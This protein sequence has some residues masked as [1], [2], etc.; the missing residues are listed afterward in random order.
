MII[1]NIYCKETC[2]L[3]EFT[4]KALPRPTIYF[5]YN[6]LILTTIPHYIAIYYTYNKNIYYSTIIM[7]STISSILW[8]NY[9]TSK[10]L[11]IIDHSLAVLLSIYE[12]LNNIQNQELIIYITI[13]TFFI[14]KITDILAYYNILNYKIGHSLFHLISSIKTIYIASFTNV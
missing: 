2:K 9:H 10:Y 5:Q 1:R 13:F 4:Y 6:L 7:S 11:Y 3:K 14:N 12:I 8:H